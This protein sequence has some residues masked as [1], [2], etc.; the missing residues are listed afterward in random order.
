MVALGAKPA[1]S[2]QTLYWWWGRA[3]APS[4]CLSDDTS[5]SR[6]WILGF[7]HPREGDEV[8]KPADAGAPGEA[9]TC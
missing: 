9:L 2:P 6:A 5:H 8:D 7:T 4:S 1:L 3:T